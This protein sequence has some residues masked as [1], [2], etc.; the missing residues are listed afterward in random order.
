MIWYF[1]LATIVIA[2]SLFVRGG[3]VLSTSVVP[4]V[5]V[6]V[7]VCVCQLEALIIRGLRN[8]VVA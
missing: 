2:F 1:M 6:C 4:C 3:G 5:C 7:C 8:V